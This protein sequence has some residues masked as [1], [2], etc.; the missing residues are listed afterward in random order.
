M[1]NKAAALLTIAILLGLAGIGKMVHAE[2][3]KP[4][5]ARI[6]EVMANQGAEISQWTLY[7]KKQESLAGK[8][9]LKY[10]QRFTAEQRLFHWSFDYK[11]NFVKAIGTRY[12]SQMKS[13]E[14]LQVISTLTK[15]NSQAYILYQAQGK[16]GRRDWNKITQVFGQQ[17]FDILKEKTAIFSCMNGQFGDK[18]EGVLQLKAEALLHEF[19][20]VPRE[21]AEEKD[22]VSVSALTSEWD[23]SI[24]A[25]EGKMNIQIA[26]RNAGIG[27]KP[28]VVIGTPII[29]TEY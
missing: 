19:N 26:L 24:P 14:K 16:G 20:A 23:L 28:T 21:K 29:T 27:E 5:I 1:R 4:V 9:P 13:F 10:V 8:N 12:N 11:D 25:K 18:I 3:K 15:G 22:F 6:A 17:S 2:A 7:S